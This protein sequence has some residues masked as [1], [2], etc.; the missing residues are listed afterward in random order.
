VGGLPDTAPKISQSEPHKSE[1]TTPNLCGA[2]GEWRPPAF[3]EGLDADDAPAIL[4]DL[5]GA[6]QIDTVDRLQAMQIALASD[7]RETLRR[8]SHCIKG[9]AGQ[10]GAGDLMSLC[11]EIEASAEVAPMEGL[12][13]LAVRVQEAF[14]DVSES[15]AKYLQI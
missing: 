11:Q 2:L 8:M 1:V 12:A 10:M 13:A 9:S 7:D 3:L 4:A 6:F 15:M 14:A 5:V